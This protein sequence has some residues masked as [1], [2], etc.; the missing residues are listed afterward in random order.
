MVAPVCPRCG[1]DVGPIAAVV[2]DVCGFCFELEMGW[3][4]SDGNEV[5]G[6]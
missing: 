5:N 2:L 3:L 4:A 6:G 1:G